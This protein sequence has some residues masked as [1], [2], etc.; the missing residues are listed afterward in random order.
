MSNTG[1]YKKVPIASIKIGERFRK[2]YHN[3]E[4]LAASIKNRMLYP[5]ILNLNYE[6]CEGGRRLEA[7][8]FLNWEEIP[9]LI[10]P[11]S[12]EIDLRE[13]ELLGNLEREDF[14]WAEQVLLIEEIHKLHAQK[15][16]SWSGRKTAQRLNRSKSLIA[17]QLKLAQR[18]K[19]IPELKNCKTESEAEKTINNVEETL[20]LQEL[21]E[22]NKI[23]RDDTLDLIKRAGDFIAKVDADRAEKAKVA[24]NIPT[25]SHP[26]EKILPS[27][28][29]HAS[30]GYIVA[31]FFEAA[32]TLPDEFL[33]FCSLIECDPDFG[34]D[35][36]LFLKRTKDP[37]AYHTAGVPH[38]MYP[39][40]LEK[41]A[42]ECFRL[43]GDRST[44]IFWFGIEWYKEV[45]EALK[46][47]G[48]KLN[49]NPAI[50]FKPGDNYGTAHNPN[51]YLCNVTEYFFVASKG[52]ATLGRP[53]SRNVFEFERPNSSARIHP[54]EKPLELLESIILT[55]YVI[56]PKSKCLV[57][58]LGSGN[59]LRVCK[60]LGIEAFGFDL[61]EE[62]RNK[63]LLRT[64][65]E[66]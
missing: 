15:D 51:E 36:A 43:L 59:T 63:Y 35:P 9:A 12:E 40:F 17:K 48:F 38:H 61:S 14:A 26:T 52:R 34:I 13:L 8:K 42:K 46:E 44:L 41:L 20:L 4:S 29:V 55:C 11:E 31:D 25:I 66:K 62:Y 47:A 21:A 16:S 64:E 2:E 28:D 58:F 6:L 53:R 10:R 23:E 65:G 37:K 54:T 56:H 30:K 60:K 22:R 3:I 49:L 50:W 7:A 18:L 19:E 1:I 5:V 57:P 39:A 24:G 27:F 33:G 32:A 45:R